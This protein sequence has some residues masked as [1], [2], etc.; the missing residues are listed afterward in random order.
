MTTK[1]Y[2]QLHNTDRNSTDE[3]Y[4]ALQ[5]KLNDTIETNMI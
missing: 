2:H 1:L 5:Q 4:H 3:N